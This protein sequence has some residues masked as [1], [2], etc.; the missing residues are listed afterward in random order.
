MDPGLVVLIHQQEQL[1]LHIPAELAN[2]D[3]KTNLLPTLFAEFSDLH[4][5]GL[6][7]VIL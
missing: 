6:V 4:E 7:S 5:G 2:R 1:M 3:L